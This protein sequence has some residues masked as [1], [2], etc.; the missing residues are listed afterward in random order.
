MSLPSGCPPAWVEEAEE[1]AGGPVPPQRAP[2]ARG[3][4]GG[5]ARG[6]EEAWRRGPQAAK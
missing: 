3:W 6:P 2:E 4:R 5:G 1:G